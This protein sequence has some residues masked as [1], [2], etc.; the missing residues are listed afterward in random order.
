MLELGREHWLQFWPEG[1]SLLAAHAAETGDPRERFDPD[2]ERLAA[3]DL[4]GVLALSTAREN[5]KL[6]GYIAWY[7]AESLATK[8]FLVAEM[9]PWFVEAS[10][11][12]GPLGLRLFDYSIRD[13]RAR[14]VRKCFPHFWTKDPEKVGLAAFFARKGA[15]ETQHTFSLW[16]EEPL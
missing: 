11:R 6:V 5:G 12:S 7:I 1:Q 16:L 9:G 14:G 10:R 15:A 8:D 4:A 2:T 13:L 3:L